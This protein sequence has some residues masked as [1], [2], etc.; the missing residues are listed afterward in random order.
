M[1]V[2]KWSPSELLKITNISEATCFP[3]FTLFFFV[4]LLSLMFFNSAERQFFFCSVGTRGSFHIVQ[5]KG[6]EVVDGKRMCMN[7][8]VKV[9]V[10]HG[11]VHW[12]HISTENI[13]LVMSQAVKI[14]TTFL[15]VSDDVRE[16]MK[17]RYLSNPDYNFEKVNR[18]SMACGPM[19]KW[20]IAQVRNF[21]CQLLFKL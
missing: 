6:N 4:C 14:L 7:Q 16:K 21:I 12:F 8:K 1:S 9:S 3:F 10:W 19:V 18:A 13:S 15:C 20:A 2:H 17:T 11:L 5:A